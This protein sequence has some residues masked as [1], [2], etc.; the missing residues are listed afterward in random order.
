MSSWKIM[1]PIKCRLVVKYV[2][3]IDVHEDYHQAHCFS[4]H[5]VHNVVPV[6]QLNMGIFMGL[7]LLDSKAWIWNRTRVHSIEPVQRLDTN[8]KRN[9]AIH[10]EA[11][12]KHHTTHWGSRLVYQS[13][14]WMGSTVKSPLTSSFLK[15]FRHLVSYKHEVITT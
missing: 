8:S 15:Y 14:L 9:S 13:C 2:E 1:T 6:I 10:R 12:N 7:R 3:D 4:C 11:L 5:L